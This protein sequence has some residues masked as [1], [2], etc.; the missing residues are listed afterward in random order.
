MLDQRVYD[1]LATSFFEKQTHETKKKPDAGPASFAQSLRILLQNL[2]PP[3]SAIFSQKETNQVCI[4]VVVVVVVGRK[5]GSF[6]YHMVVSFVVVCLFLL[7]VARFESPPHLTQKGVSI[8]CS[9]TGVYGRGGQGKA[10][11]TACVCVFPSFSPIH[12]T[13]L[14]NIYGR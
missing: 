1:D 3:E 8:G 13:L 10:P 12:G 7:S 11:N 5:D 6:L 2:H 4:Y 9:T 14:N